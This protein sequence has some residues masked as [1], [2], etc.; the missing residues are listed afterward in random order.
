M[1]RIAEREATAEHRRVESLALIGDDI[2]HRYDGRPAGQH[3]SVYPYDGPI[4]RACPG[5]SRSLS[6]LPRA[7]RA[8]RFG[9]RCEV[10]ASYVMAANRGRRKGPGERGNWTRTKAVD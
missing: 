1:G 7:R 5:P 10:V 3:R 9:L 8:E 6:V 2:E 4:R